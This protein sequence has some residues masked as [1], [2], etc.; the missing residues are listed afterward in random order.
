M[1]TIKRIVSFLSSLWGALAVATVA[2]PGAAA[3]LKVPLAVE[4]SRLAQFYS[5]LPT[6][7]SSFCILFLIAYKVELA[8]LTRARRV[9]V[10]AVAI[11]FLCFFSFLGV[12]VYYLDIDA[13]QIIEE[14]ADGQVI[15][16]EQS[17]GLLLRKYLTGD[18]VTY[19]DRRADPY[20]ILSLALF[21]A[22]FAAL[23]LG[24][25]S[26]GIYTYQIHGHA[27]AQQGAQ[28]DDLLHP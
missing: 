25:G 27:S 19:E 4:H 14:D 12:R 17:K 28:A 6:V 11:G 15:R 7:A 23:S 18:K 3:L 22:S 9:A 16:V 24:F 5:L 13:T 10:S 26:L 20:D 1:V 2:F 21:T 8:E